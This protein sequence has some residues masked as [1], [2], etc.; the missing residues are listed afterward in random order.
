MTRQEGIN[1]PGD[2]LPGN[3]EYVHGYSQK[4]ALRLSDQA[5]TLAGLLHHDTAFPAG[6]R[7][8]EVGC[9]TG[10]QTC[11]LTGHSP[12]AIVVSVDISPESLDAA[13]TRMD[14]LGRPDHPFVRADLFSLPFA[15]GIFDH[16]FLCFVL[17]H[18]KD[19]ARALVALRNCLR[20]GGTITVIEGNHGSCYFHPSTPDAEHAWKCLVDTQAGIGGNSLVGRELYPLLVAAGFRDVHVSPRMVYSDHSTPSLQEGFVRKTIIPMVEGIRERAIREE[21]I[22]PAVFDQG[23]ADLHA[24]ASPGGTFCYTFFKGTAT[25]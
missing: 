19:P 1:R 24:T 15:E 16:V 10:C 14:E 11:I 3:D 5:S 12:G 17:E 20:P 25:R 9:G 8:L 18:L 4:E 2:P 23:I 7:V 6:S 22:P 21:R 13:R